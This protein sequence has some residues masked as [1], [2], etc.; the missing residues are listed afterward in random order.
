MQGADKTEP[1]WVDRLCSVPRDFLGDKTI[2]GLFQEASPDL[3]DR[4][5]F[6]ELVAGYLAHHQEL[7]ETWQVYS[8]DKRVDQGPYL[9]GTEV[10]FYSAG[11]RAVQH[12]EHPLDA[13]ADFIYLEASWVLERR[14]PEW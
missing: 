13:C 5:E 2:I 6:V 11:R 14:A 10:G 4:Q 9:D 8:Y 7:L 1:E 3:S 12:Y